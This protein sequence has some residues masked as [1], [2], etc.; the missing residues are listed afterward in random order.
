MNFWAFYRIKK[1]R[2]YLLYVYIPFDA[3][4]LAKL[5]KVYFMI[6]TMYLYREVAYDEHG[7]HLYGGAGGGFVYKKTNLNAWRD[8]IQK[9]IDI[10]EPPVTDK[11][12]YPLEG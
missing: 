9:A 5:E 4:S 8:A 6:K 12:L 7:K 10:I 3:D 11:Y 2:K 1:L